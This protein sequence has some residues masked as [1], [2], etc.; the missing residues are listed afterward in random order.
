[1]I[2]SRRG[3]LAAPVAAALLSG[4][5]A[6]PFKGMFGSNGA[7]KQAFN[8]VD[9]TGAQYARSFSLPD[10]N[11]TVRT[12]ADFKGKV[13]VLFFGYTQ[14]PDVCPTSLAELAA[15][16]QSLGKDGERVQALFVTVDPERDTPELL[17]A[18]M[19]NFDPTFLAL[20]GTLEQTKDTAK[21][22][23]A[24]YA[25]VPGKTPETYT[26]DHTAAFYVFRPGRQ[27][28]PLHPARSRAGAAGGRPE[29][30]ARFGE[31]LDKRIKKRPLGAVFHDAPK[32]RQLRPVPCASSS[33]PPLRSG[34]SARR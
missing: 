17:K 6:G 4:C 24:Y 5:D 30:A 20:R 27:D 34:G 31:R 23:K 29:A 21:E 2:T 26:M 12:L 25:K 19:N 32:L 1:M 11:G 7:P 10:Q 9:L 15:A 3:F 8:G 14:C 22:F 28:P 16:R 18:Y 33:S 13:C